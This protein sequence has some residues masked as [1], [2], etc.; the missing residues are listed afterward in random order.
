MKPAVKCLCFLHLAFFSLG[1]DA[2]I[3]ASR[4]KATQSD[5]YQS[6]GRMPPL[7]ARRGQQR[8][9]VLVKHRIVSPQNVVPRPREVPNPILSKCSQLGQSCVPLWGCCGRCETCHCRFF[10]AIC[11]C[12]KAKSQCGIKLLN[13]KSKKRPNPKKTL[14]L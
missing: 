10:N 3:S 11:F 13:T 2:F 9:G 4:S 7:F 12:R 14:G 1:L 5:G 6:Q 8:L